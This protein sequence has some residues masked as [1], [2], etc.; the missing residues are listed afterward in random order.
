MDANEQ[1]KQFADDLDNLVDRYRD[2]YD[3]N[4]AAVVGALFMKA[5]LLCDEAGDEAERN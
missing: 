2:E 4:Y 1:V 5:H 3:L